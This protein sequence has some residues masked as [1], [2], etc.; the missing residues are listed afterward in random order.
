MGYVCIYMCVYICVYIYKCMCKC[1]IIKYLSFSLYSN[2]ILGNPSGFFFIKHNHL[3][4]PLCLQT[5][6]SWEICLFW[7]KFLFQEM[8]FRVT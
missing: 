2:I 7:V 3:G 4:E 5:K 8:N 6:V 1:N